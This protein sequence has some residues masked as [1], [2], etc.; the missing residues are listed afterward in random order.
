M[1][2]A[3]IAAV[4][5]TPA[6]LATH[7]G[8][9]PCCQAVLGWLYSREQQPALRPALQTEPVWASMLVANANTAHLLIVI[10][11]PCFCGCAA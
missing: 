10:L 8:R 3:E 7:A 6:A 1:Q 2:D 4:L 11:P 5:M 9:T